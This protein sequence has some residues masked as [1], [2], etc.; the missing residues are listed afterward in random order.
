MGHLLRALLAGVAVAASMAIPS[1]AR[2]TDSG[3][4]HEPSADPPLPPR[5][6]DGDNLVDS[7]SRRSWNEGRPRMFAAT[8]FDV[9]WVY[10]RP[11]L[12]IGWGNP[13]NTW[14]GVDM[15][16]VVSGNG[17][18]A[19]GG[20][21][22]ALPRFDIRAGSRYVFA[23]NREYLPI[24]EKYDRLDLSSTVGEPARIVTHEVEAE[25]SIPLGPGDIIGLG[26][27]S[28][29][30]NIPE[31]RYVFE[32]TLRVIVA[33]P[34]VW[35]GRGGYVIR[36]GSF[37]QHSLGVVADVLDVPKRDDSRT[38]RAGVVVRV[39]LSRHVEV[40]GSFVPTIISPDKL[41]VVGGDFTELGFRYRWATN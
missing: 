13:F 36:F 12:S 37:S 20:L 34:I 28:Y 41:G 23:F 3:V 38:V 10:V 18:G 26:S 25:F 31:N 4:G 33:P 30:R 14:F 21:R 40:R 19:Y 6:P 22:L 27:L 17:L 8:T 24:Q 35:R 11:R 2:A 15:N 39:V 32:E 9:G 29:V 5:G 1:V 16:P 7:H